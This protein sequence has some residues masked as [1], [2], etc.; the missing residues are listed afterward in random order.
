[1]LSAKLSN[2]T[3]SFL[4]YNLPIEIQILCLFWYRR[5]SKA[6]RGF[7]FVNR[8]TFFHPSKTL[9][10]L[11]TQGLETHLIPVFLPTVMPKVSSKGKSP[12]ARLFL[13][14]KT[15]TG[16]NPPNHKPEAF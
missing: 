1:D 12:S 11:A 16:T 14:P 4:L 13:T 8:S 5:K 3:L 9:Q 6:N 15:T 2:L 10:S 7:F